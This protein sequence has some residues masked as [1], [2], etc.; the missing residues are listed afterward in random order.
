MSRRS[1]YST[2]WASLLWLRPWYKQKSPWLAI[3]AC[4]IG[5]TFTTNLLVHCQRHILSLLNSGIHDSPIHLILKYS[6]RTQKPFT[7]LVWVKFTKSV[8]TTISSKEICDLSLTVSAIAMRARVYFLT[9]MKLRMMLIWRV[10]F[11]CISWSTK[12][13]RR[14]V[15]WLETLKRVITTVI[16]EVA[17]PVWVAS[18]HSSSK[19]RVRIR[20]TWSTIQL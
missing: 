3:I 9:I 10:W 12:R 14:P 7:I 18:S 8:P 15:S 16:T 13:L 5:F 19:K 6:L 20:K 2:K 4:T 1:F 17:W 11:S